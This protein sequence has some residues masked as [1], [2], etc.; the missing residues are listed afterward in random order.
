M[1][2]TAGKL[3]TEQLD[4]MQLTF[5]T[6]P[7]SMAVLFPFFLTREVR[8][9]RTHLADTTRQ[10]VPGSGLSTALP[11]TCRTARVSWCRAAC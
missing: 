6:A 2:C 5:Y 10:S 4:V 3:L 8:A 7:A 1:M 11:A 9:L